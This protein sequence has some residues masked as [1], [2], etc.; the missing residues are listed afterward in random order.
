MRRIA[1]LITLLLVLLLLRPAPGQEADAG[2][3]MI[4][5]K[6]LS[7]GL[8]K[9]KETGRILMICVNAKYVEG[10]EKEESAAKGLREVVYKDPRVV[11]KSRDFV[12]VL[13]TPKSSTADYGELGSLGIEG[14]IVSPQHIFVN[15]AGDRVLLRREYWSYGRGE[16]AV[17]ALLALMEKAEEK[18]GKPGAAPAKAPGGGEAPAEGE[19][20]A[21]WIALM[22]R[23]LAAGSVGEQQQALRAL[24]KG[25]KDGDC[26]APLI[27][28]LP[29]NKKNT[30]FLWPLIRALGRDGLEDAARPISAFLHHRDPSIRGCAAVSLEYI[31][32]REKKV[33]VALLKAVGKQKDE[34]IA[35][36]I[37]RALG[38]CGVKDPKVRALLLKMAASGKSEFSTYG[39]AIGLAYFEGDPKAARG[40]EKLLKLIGIPGGRRGGG[41]NTVKRGLLS[42]TLA[43]IGDRKSSRFVRGELMAKLKNVKAFWVDGLRTFW[44]TVARVCEGEDSEMAAIEAGVRGFVEFTKRFDL[45]RYGAETRHLMDDSRTGRDTSNFKPKGDNLLGSGDD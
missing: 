34:A 19:A 43:S 6:D 36:H 32:S 28:L 30:D 7:T 5:S 10:R 1:S 3:G 15:A 22:L 45:A 27:A 31:G 35:N 17:V 8:A 20:R 2:E 44:D 39:P 18:S 4:W 21:E 11:K 33:V 24:V 25:D 38:R 16:K 26:T 14:R 37:Y 23:Q 29:E 9:A 13:L 42:W 41:Q 12:C 40:V